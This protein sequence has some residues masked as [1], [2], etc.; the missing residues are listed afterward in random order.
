LLAEATDHHPHSIIWKSIWN[1]DGM[2]KN[3]FLCWL[4]VHN[5]IPTSENMK[6][7]GI[8]GPSCCIL[9][10]SD[11]ESIQHLFIEFQFAREFWKQAL[12]TLIDR[13]NWP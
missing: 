13:F 11:E 12:S 5:K 9:Y 7:I 2:P 1:S 10:Q 6:K 3:N 4:L 8:S